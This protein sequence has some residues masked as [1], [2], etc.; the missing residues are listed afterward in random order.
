MTAVNRTREDDRRWR[1]RDREAIYK[2]IGARPTHSGPRPIVPDRG[3]GGSQMDFAYYRR[4][5]LYTARSPQPTL[6]SGVIVRGTL[7]NAGIK[8]K[9]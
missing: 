6:Q 5:Y 8:G 9:Y 2:E 1:E 7:R 4:R 3:I